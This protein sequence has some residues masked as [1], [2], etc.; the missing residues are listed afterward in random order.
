MCLGTLP[1]AA[2]VFRQ[3]PPITGVILSCPQLCYGT[4][5]FLKNYLVRLPILFV[6]LFFFYVVWDSKRLT[7]KSN[8]HLLFCPRVPPISTEAFLFLL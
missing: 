5:C 3:R 8:G 7:Y 1:T 6:F 2:L 4:F